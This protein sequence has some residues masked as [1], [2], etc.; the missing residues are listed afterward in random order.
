MKTEDKIILYL[1]NQLS[2]EDRAMFEKELDNSQQLRTELENYK[3]FLKDINSVKD[4]TAGNDYFAE[5]I[6]KFRGR[7]ELKQRMRFL[8]K[9]AYGTTAIAV[10]LAVLFLLVNKNVNNKES[11][12]FNKSLQSNKSTQIEKIESTSDMNILSDQFNIGELSQ[13][14]IIYSN[15]VLDSLL[16]EELNLSPQNLNDFT[17]ENNQDLNTI[18]QGINEKEANDIYNQL[19]HKKIF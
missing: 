14:D 4:I 11:I 19:L 5:M 6:P 10:V 7:L 12:V 16:Y 8:P 13:S 9:L 2:A 15:S 18:V 3:K 17:F 1:D